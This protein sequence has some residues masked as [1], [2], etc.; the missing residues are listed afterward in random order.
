MKDRKRFLVIM[1]VVTLLFM[2][3]GCKSQAEKEL[4]QAR[5]TA[6]AAE[7][8]LDRVES[9][10]DRTNSL[11][12]EYEYLQDLIPTLPDGSYEKEAAI[13]RNN[14]IVRELMDTYPELVNYVY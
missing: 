4:E 12:E 3:S 7:A 14:A 6:D 2:F 5:A 13:A 9:E 8:Q 11:I 1:L 10:Y